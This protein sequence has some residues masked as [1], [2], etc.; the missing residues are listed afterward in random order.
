MRDAM[1]P[2]QREHFEVPREIC[3]LNA[4]S[5]SPLPRKTID[6]ARAAVERKGQPWRIPYSFADEQHERARA[7]AARLIDADPGD[8]ALISSVSYGVATAA[9]PLTIP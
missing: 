7:A 8:V 4:A 2:C 3:Y 1:L 9:K 5:W 6:A